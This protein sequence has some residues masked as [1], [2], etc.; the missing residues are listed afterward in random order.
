MGKMNKKAGVGMTMGNLIFI[1]LIVLVTIFAVTS[2]YRYQNGAFLWEQYY[3]Y[4]V[5]KVVNEAKVGDRIELNMDKAVEIAKKNGIAELSKIILFDNDKKEVI[6]S[7]QSG[8]GTA[9][10]FLRNY[11]IEFFPV[12]DSAKGYILVFNVKE[13]G[14]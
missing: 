3:S 12:E 9:F 2:I 8:R 5:A 7:F 4:S 13:G 10:Q 6:V 1:I 11:N 14:K